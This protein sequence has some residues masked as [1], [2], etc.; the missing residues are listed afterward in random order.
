MKNLLCTT[1]YRVKTPYAID[2]LLV[3]VVAAVEGLD[4]FLQVTLVK[5]EPSS[6]TTCTIQS[7]NHFVSNES[8][9]LECMGIVSIVQTLAHSLQLNNSDVET[10]QVESWLQSLD[11][12]LLVW[13]RSK[14]T[15][16]E[17]IPE[18]VTKGT[19]KTSTSHTH[20]HTHTLSFEKKDSL[21]DSSLIFLR[22]QSLHF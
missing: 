9:T 2:Q 17:E 15:G 4:S 7:I 12:S 18:A 21:K 8:S 16:D 20:T 6:T 22:C 11:Q 3:E 5:K 13:L 10:S 14:N 1:S 19:N